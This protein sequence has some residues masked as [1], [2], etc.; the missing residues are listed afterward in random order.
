[1]PPQVTRQTAARTQTAKP[2]DPAVFGR[3]AP[4][5]FD[6][7]DGIKINLYGRP[8]TGKTTLW[9]T[10]PKPILS[11]ICS[12]GTNPG[13]LRSLDTPEYRQSIMQVTLLRSSELSELA[14]HPAV[15]KYQTVVLDHASGFQDMVLAEIL[16]LSE[17]PAQIT[18]GLASQQQ[19]GQLAVQVKEH[20]RAMLSLRQNVVIVAQ[21]REFNTESSSEV[22]EPFVAAGL[23]PSIT[24]WL[25]NA[26]DYICQTFIRQKEVVES[27]TVMQAGKP[28]KVQTRKKSNQVEYCLRV[29]PHA[30][31]ATKFRIPKGY[32]LPDVIVDPDYYKIMSLIRPEQFPPTT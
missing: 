20:L 23:T 15:N 16:G 19:Y 29:A 11:V 22:V 27:K 8:A 17:L 5:G 1:M 25:N 31:Y 6:P 3:I 7:S 14:R 2:T 24:G 26:V 18:W 12:G 10:F 30:T 13:E 21:E 28:V 4:I 9:A 32:V